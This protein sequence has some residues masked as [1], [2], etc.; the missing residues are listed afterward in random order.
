MNH[1]VEKHFRRAREAAA[2][3]YKPVF[4]ASFEQNIGLVDHLQRYMPM[5]LTLRGSDGTHLATA[6]LPASGQPD[7][8]FR[9]IIVG[10]A[11]RDPYPEHK[12]AIDALGQ[13]C[14]ISLERVR[15]YPYGRP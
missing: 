13:H 15:C 12:A 5:F 6:M 9:P 4:Q 8:S 2:A 10:F 11:N 1:S 3:S 7:P 14:G